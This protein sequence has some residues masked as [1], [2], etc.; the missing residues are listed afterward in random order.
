MKNLE[1]IFAKLLREPVATITDASNRETLKRWDSFNHLRLV[2]A[3]ED[4]YNVE[5]STTEVEGIK[6]VGMVKELLR[7]KGV[8]L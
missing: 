6:T 2:V 5:F 7:L 4:A 8:S 3:L 1:E